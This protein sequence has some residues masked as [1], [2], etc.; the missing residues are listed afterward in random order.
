MNIQSIKHRALSRRNPIEKNIEFKCQYCHKSYKI[1][2]AYMNHKCKIKQRLEIMRTNIGQAAYA[3]YNTWMTLSRKSKQSPET[4]MSSKYFTSFI[5]FAE[6]CEKI[7]LDGIAFIE[8]MVKN[9]PDISPVLWTLSEVY[10]KFLRMYDDKCDPL[11]QAAISLEYIDKQIELYGCDK[12]KI[13]YEMGF[14]KIIEAY[15]LKKLS[16]WFLFTADIGL[17]YFSNL[18]MDEMKLF[19]KI[20]DG[21]G[22][23]L[24]FRNN[25][26]TFEEIKSVVNL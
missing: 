13:L 7:S 24:K 11:N 8:I 5:K 23:E 10:S 20:I 16:P 1:E 3:N 4:F 18:S 17:D 9:Y 25:M 21:D 6:Y 14:N 12:T 19:D 2:S 26:E 15:R 22:W